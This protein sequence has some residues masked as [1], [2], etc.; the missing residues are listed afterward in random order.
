MGLNPWQIES[1]ED[2]TFICCPECIFKSKDSD[3]FKNHALENHPDSRDFFK[4][5]FKDSE[6]NFPLKD[7]NIDFV[8]FEPQKV[9]ETKCDLEFGQV[10]LL[11]KIVDTSSGNDDYNPEEFDFSPEK[12]EF[13]INTSNDHEDY[14]LKEEPIVEITEE[15]EKKPKKIVLTSDYDCLMCSKKCFSKKDRTLH[16]KANHKEI[17]CPKCSKQ[18][19]SH[20]LLVAHDY[21]V[22][23]SAKC[24]YCAKTYVNKMVLKKHIKN[25]HEVNKE[26]KKF[27]CDQCP[28]IGYAAMYLY[29]HK[30]TEHKMKNQK[31]KT[32]L[33]EK[34]GFV[35]CPLCKKMVKKRGLVLH[36]KTKHKEYP[37]GYDGDLFHCEYCPEKFHKKTLLGN[38]IRKM[39]TA[40]R[41][42]KKNTK[43]EI[44]D[45]EYKNM[46][47]YVIHYK[48]V[49]KDFPPEYGD[50][51]RFFVKNVEIVS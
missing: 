26:D 35:E 18:F 45:I 6:L 13:H 47:G 39:H 43:C 11:P 16:V 23:Q 37:P 21:R 2:L 20:K 12:I 5:D 24:H 28:Y 30:L 14:C 29:H 27:Q 7:E 33:P 17:I 50:K 15:I 25:V 8:N 32:D 49:H 4:T 48:N 46:M 22:H 10:E 3:N 36:Y 31:P 40:K 41:N 51:P 42:E 38:H 9:D 1:L 34:D 44:C 19:A